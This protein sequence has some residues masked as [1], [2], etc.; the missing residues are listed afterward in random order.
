MENIEFIPANELPVS[1]AEAVSV[2]CLEN[3][4]LKQKPGASLGGAGGYVLV[5]TAENMT[6]DGSGTDFSQSFTYNGNRDDFAQLLY[7]GGTLWIDMTVM[8]G[9][10]TRVAVS[11]W[12]FTDDALMLMA[13]YAN[14][15]FVF[16]CPNGTWTP[17]GE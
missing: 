6:S 14:M 11:S 4:E 17:P 3:G 13:T 12:A 2:L 8:T 7:N 9:M 10:V 1:E 5:A 15:M 16:Q